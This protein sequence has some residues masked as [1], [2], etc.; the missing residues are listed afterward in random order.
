MTTISEGFNLNILD[1][2]KA[3]RVFQKVVREEGLFMPTPPEYS[4]LISL[5]LITMELIEDVLTSLDS[6]FVFYREHSKKLKGLTS[7]RATK[8]RKKLYKRANNLFF[9]KET[10][11]RKLSYSYKRSAAADPSL[12]SINYEKLLI[13]CVH[14]SENG[15]V[16]LF[17]EHEKQ[18]HLD[19]LL[20]LKFCYKVFSKIEDGRISSES[21]VWEDD[22]QYIL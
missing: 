10:I 2:R 5:D 21:F 20:S 9:Q 8:F 16:S 19:Q 4:K 14:I 15:V 18:Y 22:L 13:P 7:K 3:D 12:K 17:D 6:R 11:I 1:R